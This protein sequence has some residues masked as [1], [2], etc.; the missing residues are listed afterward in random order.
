M[1]SAAVVFALSYVL[2]PLCSLLLRAPQYGGALL[3]PSNVLHTKD[4]TTAAS[5]TAK[6]KTKKMNQ[7]K[8]RSQ[9]KEQVASSFHEQPEMVNRARLLTAPTCRAHIHD[10]LD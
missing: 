3:T 7:K 6:T 10:A 2:S 9:L 8:P 4:A 1:L 5:L